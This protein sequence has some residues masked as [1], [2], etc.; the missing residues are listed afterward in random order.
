MSATDGFSL[1]CSEMRKN[2]STINFLETETN[3]QNEP[4]RGAEGKMHRSFDLNHLPTEDEIAEMESPLLAV[5]AQNILPSI[6]SQNPTSQP[7]DDANLRSIHRNT[8]LDNTTQPQEGAHLLQL[9]WNKPRLAPHPSSLDTLQ[10]WPLPCP[11]SS[12]VVYCLALQPALSEH[13]TGSMVINLP[14]MQHLQH[15]LHPST[16]T[17]PQG[18]DDQPQQGENGLTIHTTARHKQQSNNHVLTLGTTIQQPPA[19]PRLALKRSLSADKDKGKRRKLS[20][21]SND[22]L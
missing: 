8:Y 22:Q 12:S 21:H 13:A 11:L 18:R 3:H 20:D 10:L 16:T 1:T 2:H 15:I 7:P 19:R 17:I 14:P 4:N 6:L 5:H 9:H